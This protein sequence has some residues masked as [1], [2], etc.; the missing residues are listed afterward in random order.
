MAGDLGGGEAEPLAISHEP[1]QIHG[2]HGCQ[3]SDR[4]DR[5]ACECYPLGAAN[6]F[7]VSGTLATPVGASLSTQEVIAGTAVEVVRSVATFQAVVTPA[8]SEDIAPAVAPQN[9]VIRVAEQ[10]VAQ[11]TADGSFDVAQAVEPS[12]VGPSK[13]E[14]NNNARVLATIRDEITCSIPDDDVVAETGDQH[15]STRSTAQYVIPPTA[16][17]R[18]VTT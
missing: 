16:K 9:V 13:R 7:A 15:I 4:P 12:A 17:D 8:A 5:G 6:A 10:P 18:I 3:R 1:C 2:W 14:V 11:R